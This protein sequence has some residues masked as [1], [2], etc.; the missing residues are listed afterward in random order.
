VEVDGGIG[1]GYGRP[2]RIG[3]VSGVQ[4]INLSTPAPVAA[5]VHAP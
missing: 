1:R 3:G 5:P 2:D 4:N